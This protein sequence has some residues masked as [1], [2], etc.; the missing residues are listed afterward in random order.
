MSKVLYFEMGYF[1]I[2]SF[3]HLSRYSLS[4]WFSGLAKKLLLGAREKAPESQYEWKLTN[5]PLECW[6]IQIFYLVFHKVA[7]C[8][9]IGEGAIP[10]CSI[11][12]WLMDVSHN[13]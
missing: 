4:A 6:H 1:F 2:K 9:T 10:E 12:E 5:V 13:M 11:M 8:V 7:S 3:D